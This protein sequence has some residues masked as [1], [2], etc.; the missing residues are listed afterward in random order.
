MKALG[1]QAGS[2]VFTALFGW[3]FIKALAGVAVLIIGIYILFMYAAGEPGRAIMPEDVDEAVKRLEAT[4]TRTADDSPRA[5]AIAQMHMQLGN[6][7]AAKTELQKIVQADPNSRYGRWAERMIA[8]LE[9]ERPDE[10]TAEPDDE[11][12]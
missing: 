10:P 9:P 2:E 1:E 5:V 3:R 8:Q 7:E 11:E 4:R 12:E 6:T